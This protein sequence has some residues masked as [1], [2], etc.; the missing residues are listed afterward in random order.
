MFFILILLNP[1]WQ[2]ITQV[3]NLFYFPVR[4]LS[5]YP[6]GKITSEIILS[7]FHVYLMS[8]NKKIKMYLIWFTQKFAVEF[9]TSLCLIVGFQ[10]ILV[11]K[12]LSWVTY[13][14]IPNFQIR[15]VPNFEAG[16]L[17]HCK[18]GNTFRI[19]KLGSVYNL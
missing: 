15:N 3:S 12:T 10:K 11:D 7:Y 8:S 19:L 14:N 13:S 9:F 1:T 16:N 2:S 6:L 4:N 5:S 18:V 17:P